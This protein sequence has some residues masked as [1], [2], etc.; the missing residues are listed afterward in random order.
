MDAGGERHGVDL[1]AV[2]G[3]VIPGPLVL[4][5][6]LRP[7]HAFALVAD[8][9]V[10]HAPLLVL[11]GCELEA[12]VSEVAAFAAHRPV[13][14]WP[15][16]EAHQPAFGLDCALHEVIVAQLQLGDLQ[17]LLG[18]A[19]AGGELQGLVGLPVEGEAQVPAPLGGVLVQHRV[20]ADRGAGV[21]VDREVVLVDVHVLLVVDPAEVAVED[22]RVR[23]LHDRGGVRDPGRCVAGAERG[24][25]GVELVGVV[26]G[27]ETVAADPPV[28]V[29][30]P[31]VGGEVDTVEAPGQAEASSGAA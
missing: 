28:Q 29:H 30:H 18:P 24:G 16:V 3:N 17:A 12:V 21:G 9:G 7:E 6:A 15:P 26:A 10:D 25:G 14:V 2:V 11:D 20:D 31:Q 19:V 4:V 5:A 13:F 27:Q 22:Q 8:A 23:Q 1:V